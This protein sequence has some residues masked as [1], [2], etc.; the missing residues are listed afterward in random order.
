MEW[1]EWKR[2]GNEIKNH[3]VKTDVNETGE[4]GWL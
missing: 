2:T 4:A 3:T 1:S